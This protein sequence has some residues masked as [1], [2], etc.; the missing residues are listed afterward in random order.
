EEKVVFSR[1]RNSLLGETGALEEAFK[2]FIPPI[3]DFIANSE[4]E[5]WDF[6]CSLRH[7]GFSPVILRS[8]DVYGY[9]SCRSVVPDKRKGEGESTSKVVSKKPKA[10]GR[11]VKRKRGRKPW[12]SSKNR[13]KTGSGSRTRNSQGTAGVHPCQMKD[14]EEI[15]R[16]ATPQLISVR[17]VT[18]E[19]LS[20]GDDIPA[21]RRKAE[22]LMNVNLTP[23]LRLRRLVM[24][25]HQL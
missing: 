25:I 4:D 3:K 9:S 19:E 22:K 12:T 7:E 23:V 20:S 24:P 21:A 6:L 16:A 14:L 11:R 2:L 13:K 1:S 15:W 18:L 17:S 8:K 10:V 5:I